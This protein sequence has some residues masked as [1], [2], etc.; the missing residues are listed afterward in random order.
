MD[1]TRRRGAGRTAVSRRRGD[2]TGTGAGR[3]AFRPEAPPWSSRSHSPSNTPSACAGELGLFVVG[4][5]VGADDRDLNHQRS[6][7][8]GDPLGHPSRRPRLGPTPGPDP[9][10]PRPGRPTAGAP[11]RHHS[12]QP[13]P[14]V[15]PRS[16]PF[17]PRPDPALAGARPLPGVCILRRVGCARSVIVVEARGPE[18]TGRS[19]GRVGTSAALP[20]AR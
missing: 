2:R 19:S 16:G 15:A 4:Q 11:G 5:R 8:P 12:R 17:D 7:T 18:A 1:S 13:G 9:A 10:L 3:T 6:R 14:D 20:N